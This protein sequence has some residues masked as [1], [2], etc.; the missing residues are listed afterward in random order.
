[1][2]K[3]ESKQKALVTVFEDL[4]TAKRAVA[5]LHQHGF[6]LNKIELVTGDV[7]EE[8]PE[9]ETPKVHDTTASTMLDSSLEW[10]TLGVAAGAIAGLVVPFPG[11]GLGMIVMGGLTGAI[12]GGMAGLEHAADDDSVNLPTIDEYER[13]VKDGY[14]LVVLLGSHEEAMQAEQAIKEMPSI[15]SH[16]HPV[17]GHEFHEHPS[18]PG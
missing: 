18:K 17:G 3:I 5:A 13:L 15:H 4:E 1:M 6:P 7:A 2:S 8:A 10:G 14:P 12:V 16:L 11:L 9:V